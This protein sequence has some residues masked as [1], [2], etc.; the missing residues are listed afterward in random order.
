MCPHTTTIC[1][2]MLLCVSSCGQGRGA[3]EGGGLERAG[4]RRAVAVVACVLLAA[5]ILL[6]NLN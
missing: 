5:S 1:V 6:T 3:R 4:G 2:L